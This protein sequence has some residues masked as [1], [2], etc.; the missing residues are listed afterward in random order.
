MSRS[1]PI[2]SEEVQTY[3]ADTCRPLLRG[4]EVGEVELAAWG[5]GHYP[6]RR[7]PR[8]VLPAVKSVGF[9]DARHDQSWGLDW[10]R[11]EG[12]ELTFLE[13]GRIDFAVDGQ[14][15]HLRP[16]DLTITRPWQRHRVGDPHVGAGRLHWLI[17][18]VGVRR[19]NQPWR[20]PSW[21]I[22]TDDDRAELTRM[23]QHNEQ[24]VWSVAPEM[25]H[26]FQQIAATIAIDRADVKS[27]RLAVKLNELFLLLLETLRAR[28]I[29]L[30]ESLSG[31]QRTVELFL[32]DL[33][34]HSDLLAEE[35]TVR[36]MAAHCGLG[37]TQF[38]A[39]CRHL[40]N[41]SP[42]QYL[43]Q[44]RLD[45]AARLLR[46]DPQASVT[47]V[48][49]RC[50]YSSSQYFSLAF[51]RRFHCSPQAYRLKDTTSANGEG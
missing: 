26:C 28:D 22:L 24:P 3:E 13:R 37:V 31:T 6:G 12:I 5:H 11:N 33:S 39:Y 35:W 4:V 23:L 46:E 29:Y 43:N 10:H 49:I 19:P 27:S 48:A 36:R 7:L 44:A 21:L 41:A 30:D 45:T 40:T 9:W 25:R 1:I 15:F 51:G 32:A 17:L 20:W 47:Q 38:T 50:G 14:R 2:F 42:I 16:G 8:G 18:D 34:N